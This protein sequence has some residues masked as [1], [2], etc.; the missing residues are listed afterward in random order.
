MTDSKPWQLFTCSYSEYHPDMG[1][2]VRITLGR[3]RGRVIPDADIRELAPRGWYWNA[4]DEEFLKAY[5]DQLDRYGV[6][7][8]S[9][10]FTQLTEF[11]SGAPLVLL[12]FERLNK[13][14]GCHR[15]MFAQWW[16]ERT[17]EEVPELGAKPVTRR[18]PPTEDPLPME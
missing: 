6:E 13:T 4:S 7:H 12:C 10:I 16:Q 17:G 8:L 18:K 15:R 5:R 2:A 3:P 11:G 14:P 9:K 1:V